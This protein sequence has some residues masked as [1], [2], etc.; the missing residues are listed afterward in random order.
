MVSDSLVGK[1]EKIM[2]SALKVFKKKGPDKASVREI[3]SESGFGLGTFYLYYTDKN[4]L[5]EK[6]VLDKAMDII[7][8]AEENC[9]GEDPVERYISFVDY[10]IDYLIANPFELDLLS[11]NITWALY[12]KIEHDERLTEADSTLQF[13]LNKYENL[14]SKSYS[15]SQQ[16][17]ILAMTFD[18]MM[19]TCK[20]ALM[21]DSTL[22]I[23]EMKPVLFAVIRK[24]FNR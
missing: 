19:S 7:I 2:E 11:N 9:E 22:S 12:T 6:I 3:M 10:I 18:I 23:D 4:D 1:K 20:S 13:I 24:I 16:L 15:Q 8:K 14:F 5:K 21:E 17:Y